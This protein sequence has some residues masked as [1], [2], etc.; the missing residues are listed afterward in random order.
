MKEN[1]S[2][3]YSKYPRYLYHYVK[4]DNNFIRN[5][6]HHQFWFSDF[7]KFN[8]PFDSQLILNS[9]IPEEEVCFYLNEINETYTKILKTIKDPQSQLDFLRQWSKNTLKD[10]QIF[11][12]MDRV[13]RQDELRL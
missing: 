13:Y 10:E 6:L 3:D 12:I 7:T 1:P 9:I 11:V 4:F 2:E 5:L 8:D